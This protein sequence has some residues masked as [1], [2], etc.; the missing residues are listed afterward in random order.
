MTFDSHGIVVELLLAFSWKQ[1]IDVAGIESASVSLQA[2]GLLRYT[3][4]TEES[5]AA[6]SPSQ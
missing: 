5:D 2:S 6:I 4:E 1:I 3:P